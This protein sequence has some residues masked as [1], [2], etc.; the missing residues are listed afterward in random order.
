MSWETREAFA[1]LRAAIQKAIRM[2]ISGEDIRE[3]VE[4]AIRENRG[5]QRT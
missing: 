2:K 1:T 5:D 3:V 4:S